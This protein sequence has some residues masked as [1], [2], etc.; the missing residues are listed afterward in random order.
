MDVC[1]S[2]ATWYIQSLNKPNRAKVPPS[3][4]FLVISCWLEC[5]HPYHGS[6]S[7]VCTSRLDFWAPSVLP[8]HIVRANE[9]LLSENFIVLNIITKLKTHSFFYS[10]WYFWNP[11][12]PPKLSSLSASQTVFL[13]ALLPHSIILSLSSS[14]SDLLVTLWDPMVT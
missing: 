6:Q 2:M 14:Q 4:T 3:T 5:M 12:L 10:T 9:N 13:I 8:S 7:N 1:D 11:Y